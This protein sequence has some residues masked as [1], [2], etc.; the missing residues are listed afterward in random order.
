MTYNNLNKVSYNKL[1]KTDIIKGFNSFSKIF[2]NSKVFTTPLLIANLN[3]ENS[4]IV[5]IDIIN[6]IVNPLLE[7][8]VKV[9]FVVSKKKINKAADRN[10]IKRLL[11]ESYRLNQNILFCGSVIEAS[12]I[13]GMNRKGINLFKEKNTVK[14]QDINTDMVTLLNIINNELSKQLNVI[15]ND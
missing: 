15:K 14:L 2:N 7:K 12:L 3:I 9:G 6:D 10:R 13:I 1:R 11:R 4:G 5:K 8:K